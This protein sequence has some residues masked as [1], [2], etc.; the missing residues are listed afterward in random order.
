MRCG[1]TIDD[2]YTG[3]GAVGTDQ[4]TI[5]DRLVTRLANSFFDLRQVFRLSTQD[6]GSLHVFP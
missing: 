3:R 2:W 4:K 6:Y 5:L 1:Q